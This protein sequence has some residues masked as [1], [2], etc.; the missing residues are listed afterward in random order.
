[1]QKHSAKQ[2]S[3]SD[4]ERTMLIGLPGFCIFDLPL[5]SS[6]NWL[7]THSF[8]LAVV[9]YEPILIAFSRFAVS[10]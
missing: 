5:Y 2:P 1:M 6:L 9:G 4:G 10:A 8:M 7:H 3:G